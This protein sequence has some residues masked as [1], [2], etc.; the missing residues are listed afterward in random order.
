M[1]KN[2]NEWNWGAI[3]VIVAILFGI[4]VWLS[5]LN[6]SQVE[7]VAQGKTNQWFIPEPIS[8]KD[9]LRTLYVGLPDPSP[10]LEYLKE[11]RSYVEFSIQIMVLHSPKMFN[12]I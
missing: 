4:P 1:I 6:T 9:P 8:G 11:V 5:Y 2:F 10:T 3:G 12:L 7:I